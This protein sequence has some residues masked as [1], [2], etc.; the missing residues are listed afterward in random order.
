[1][2]M[3]ALMTVAHFRSVAMAGLLVVSDELSELK[4]H[5]GFSAPSLKEGCRSAAYLLLN[6]AKTL[7]ERAEKG[8]SVTHLGDGRR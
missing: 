6:L 5:P 8:L 1:M 3:S 2:E 4:W 7:N